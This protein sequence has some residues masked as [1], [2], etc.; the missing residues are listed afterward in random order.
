[1]RPVTSEIKVVLCDEEELG[2]SRVIILRK[3]MN[4]FRK[5]KKNKQG[6]SKE[7]KDPKNYLQLK[8]MKDPED[9]FLYPITSHWEKRWR[10]WRLQPQLET[11]RHG[12]SYIVQDYFYRRN[13][14]N[15]TLL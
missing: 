14:I 15:F 5:Q 7:Q 6:I 3:Y 9:Q 8:K 1:M 12:R 4:S 11:P 10:H 13:G 2:V